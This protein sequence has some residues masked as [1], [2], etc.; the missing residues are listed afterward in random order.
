MR[1]RAASLVRCL[2]GLLALWG[3][4]PAQ[5]DN[6]GSRATI[7]C[8]HAVE[9]PSDTHYSISRA[10]FREQMEYLRDGGFQVI[11]L[12]ELV[13]YLNGEIDEIPP[14]SVVITVDDGW[15]SVYTEMLPVLEEMDFPFTLFIYPKFVI[16]GNYALEWPE[17]REM[18]RRG[19]DIQSH[20]LS[21]HALPWASNRHLGRARWKQWVREELVESKAILERE[22]GQRVE[23]LAYPYGQS[24]PVVRAI[25]AEVGYTAGVEALFGTVTPSSD[26][27]AIE[28]VSLDRGTSFEQF[29]QYLGVARLN[30]S[31]EDPTPGTSLD[32]S[33]PLL[34]AR[35]AEPGN[36][37]SSSVRMTILGLGELP[38]AYDPRDGSLSLMLRE[39]LPAGLHRIAVW[40]TERSSG[41]RLDA[42]WTFRTEPSRLTR[43]RTS[44]PPPH[45]KR[46]G[47]R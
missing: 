19:V 32:P 28:R 8:Y 42:V 16:G 30:L 20:T 10:A 6:G 37:D 14:N 27:F 36:L 43:A 18:A 34:S 39:D 13:G 22:I 4:F 47:K 44:R 21:H 7:L 46:D 5:A 12:S 29:R 17:L 41:R 11:P 1:I 38:F 15:R 40:A 35:I 26:P 45:D 24:D 23:Y 2:L 33:L 3:A 9:S 31:D 25:A